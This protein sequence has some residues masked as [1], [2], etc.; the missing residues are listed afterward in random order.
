MTHILYMK[1]IVRITLAGIIA[2]LLFFSFIQ[3][4]RGGKTMDFHIYDIHF[5]IDY[6]QILFFTLRLIG[7][8]AFFWL[9]FKINN[10]SQ[11][12]KS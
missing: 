9:L 12:Q 8:I 5:L 6:R 1:Q 3:I 2:I 10:K 11:R 7:L 4:L